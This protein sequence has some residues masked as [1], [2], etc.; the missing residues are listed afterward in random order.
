MC[1]ELDAELPVTDSALL[2]DHLAICSKCGTEWEKLFSVH[3]N[4]HALMAQRLPPTGL[5][6]RLLAAVD[7]EARKGKI[8]FRY[9]P[10]AIS[11]AVLVAVACICIFIP[12]PQ[13]FPHESVEALVADTADGEKHPSQEHFRRL[14][15]FD[16]KALSTAA[17]SA[18][19]PATLFPI[20]KLHVATLDVYEDKHRQK[21]LRT[22]YQ[23]SRDHSFCI[24]CYQARSGLLS[25]SGT[26]VSTASGKKVLFK[27]VSDHNV[28][29][30]TKNGV[31]YV[32]ASN[33]PKDKLLSLVPEQS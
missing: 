28:V 32:Y 17:K 1:P 23:D 16:N 15:R 22:C 9:S 24:D 20:A 21:I 27:H 11:L 12:W 10:R 13:L 25:F 18:G 3:Q 4:L 5:E 29:M 2:Q 30:L 33:L 6:E 19:L 7:K 8:R 31:D 14:A 26:Q